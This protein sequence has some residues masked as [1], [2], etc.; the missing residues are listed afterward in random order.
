MHFFVAKL[1]SITVMTYCTSIPKPTSGKFVTHTANKLQHL[2][3]ARAHD[4]RPHCRLMSS[5]QRIPTNTRINFILPETRVRELHDCCYSIGLSVISFM[6]YSQAKKDVQDEPTRHHSPVTSFFL[7]KPSEY[8][9]KP[10]I[11][12]NQSPCRRYA[13]LTVCVYLYQFSRNYFSNVARCEPVKPA[14]KQNLTRHSHSGSY[15]VMHFGITEK[16]T[17]DSVVRMAV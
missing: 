9:H 7:E 11:S 8:P 6:Q 3:A 12:R 10:Y 5:F 17:T 14:R 16:Q 1:L 2:T 13:P 15:K 4:A